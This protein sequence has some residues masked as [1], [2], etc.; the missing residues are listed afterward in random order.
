[1]YIFGIIQVMTE[2]LRIEEYTTADGAKGT[3]VRKPDGKFAQG[4]HTPY[5]ITNENVSNYHRANVVKHQQA[6]ASALLSEFTSMAIVGP[7]ATAAEAWGALV[8]R[9][10]CQ[11]MD[12][13]KPRGD[14]ML[15]VGKAI[16]AIMSE[17]G[18]SREDQQNTATSW[19]EFLNNSKVSIEHKPQD[20]P[21]DVTAKDAE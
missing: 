10:A 9:V 3:I 14:D 1:M 18:L 8:A 2:Q 11:I 19:L 4:T 17:A 21:I 16:G 20:V 12:S 7:N 15:A 13:D 5:P 6:A